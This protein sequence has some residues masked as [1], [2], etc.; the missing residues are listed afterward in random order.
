MDVSVGAV[1]KI[2]SF[3]SL[4]QKK[5]LALE[6]L[7]SLPACHPGLSRANCRQMLHSH[8]TNLKHNLAKDFITKFFQNKSFNP[9]YFFNIEKTG[10][11][12]SL[13]SW[14]LN[15]NDFQFHLLTIRD[16]CLNEPNN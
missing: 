11:N 13:C 4:N 14:T 10:L 2:S 8:W 16:F 15:K 9:I 3:K 7:L 6:N 12:C 5:L 1:K